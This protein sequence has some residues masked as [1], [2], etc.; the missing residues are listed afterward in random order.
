MARP[1][2]GGR[3]PATKALGWLGRFIHPPGRSRE[4]MHWRPPAIVLLRFRPDPTSATGLRA[5]NPRWHL[6]HAT[7]VARDPVTRRFIL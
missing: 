3:I 2:Y 4:W 6:A 7:T 5:G 1:G